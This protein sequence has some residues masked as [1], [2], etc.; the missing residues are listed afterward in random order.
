MLLILSDMFSSKT[1]SSLVVFFFL[2]H[3]YALLVTPLGFVFD[4]PALAA[5]NAYSS[6]LRLYPSWS[7]F[8]DLLPYDLVLTQ[9]SVKK[10]TSPWPEKIYAPGSNYLSTIRFYRCGFCAN[11]AYQLDLRSDEPNSGWLIKKL[12]CSHSK[13]EHRVQLFRAPQSGETPYLAKEL[14]FSCSP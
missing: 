1:S 5:A 10:S 9:S 3:S 12:L 13:D 2:W 4:W 11:A 8:S 14:V 7:F 6:A